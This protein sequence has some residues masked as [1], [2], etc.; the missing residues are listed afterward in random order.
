M[1]YAFIADRCADLPVEQCCRALKVSRSAFYLW[2]H[3]RSNPTA[4][5]LADAE[6]GDLVVKVH[7]ASF[8]TYGVLRVT[9]ELRLGLG[10]EVNHKRVQRLM[11]QRGVSGVT[12][13]R[14]TKGCTRSRPG[15]PRWDDLV[16][17]QFRP[18]GPDRL[19]V[20]DIAQHRTGEGWVHCAVVID[21]WSRRVVGWSIADHLR[22]ERVI[23]PST[24]P[25]CGVDLPAPPFTATT[26]ANIAAGSSGNGSAPRG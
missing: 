16:H 4:K 10:R 21:A 24:W 5:M 22:S 1:I 3:Q 18:S 13:R 2:R 9:A 8:G 19:W 7:E 6:L 11:R 26:E 23:E 20:Q 14:R 15:D 12:R 25:S 17:R